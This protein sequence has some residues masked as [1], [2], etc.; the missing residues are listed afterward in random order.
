MKLICTIAS[1]FVIVAAANAT[2][3][4]ITCQ[5]SPAHFLPVK[6]NAVIGDTIRWIWVEG[7]HIVG[8][9]NTSD[10]PTGAAKWNATIDAGNHSFEYVV[11]VV[12]SYYYDCHPATPH[13]ENAYIVVTGISRGQQYN[14]LSDLSSAYPNPSNGAFQFTID[15]S[16]ITKNAKIEIFNLKGQIIYTSLITKTTSFIDLH[17]QKNGIYFIRFFNG[18]AI[19]TKKIVIQ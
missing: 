4:T 8:P 1:F 14:E 10:I 3:R 12:G 6:M 18:E 13:G 11:T 17:N 7:H 19:L 9:V 16:L 15:D 2:V 5:N